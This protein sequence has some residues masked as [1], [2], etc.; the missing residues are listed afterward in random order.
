M[1]TMDE[2]LTE[3]EEHEAELRA[4]PM[5]EWDALVDKAVADQDDVVALQHLMERRDAKEWDQVVELL[6]KRTGGTLGDRDYALRQ[7]SEI[8][9]R[10]RNAR[11]NPEQRE[12]RRWTDL[13]F[14]AAMIGSS[15]EGMTKL[16]LENAR[17]CLPVTRSPVRP[18]DDDPLL[19]HATYFVD[20][21]LDALLMKPDDRAG[22]EKMVNARFLQWCGENGVRAGRFD[23]S[24]KF[25]ML[26]E[27]VPFQLT[28]TPPG[29]TDPSDPLPAA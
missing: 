7:V 29:P 25:E 18:G 8:A 4:R 9:D 11:D 1:I 22:L 5:A 23:A 6:S 2:A 28:D 15:K 27:V 20:S 16:W 26:G 24:G 12:R 19:A 21:L 3:E 14:A 13:L 17:D 10:L